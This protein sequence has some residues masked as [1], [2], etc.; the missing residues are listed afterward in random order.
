MTYKFQL[1]AKRSKAFAF[2]LA[3]TVFILIVNISVFWT[4][5]YFNDIE[6]YGHYHAAT[7]PSK[8]D[9]QF[10][11]KIEL[12]TLVV[13]PHG[14]R[15]V[16]SLEDKCKGED[17]FLVVVVTSAPGH[18]KQRDAI[19]QTWGNENILPHK[20]VKVLFALGRS[21]N[22]Q[23]EN[24]VQREV[25]T[26]QDIIQEEFLDSYRNLTIKTVMVL[27]WTVTFC[28]G[29]DYLMKTDDDMFVNI[30]T[31]VS[32]LKSL[33]DDKSSDLFIGD[34]HTGV[35]ALR[36]PANKH[37]VSMEDYENEV[38]PDYLSG[39]GYVMSMDVVRRL[40]VTALM[41]SPVP[42][43]DIYMGICA[44]RAGIAPRDHSGFTSLQFGFTVCSHRKIVT[45]HSYTPT[46]LLAMW[47]ALQETP[48]CGW[49]R[50]H[51]SMVYAKL[52]NFSYMIIPCSFRG[53]NVREEE[54]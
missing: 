2:V 40:Y 31:L 27:K 51:F 30:E 28:S 44:Q 7:I 10:V 21:D 37:Y 42:V 33:K 16:N 38:Y 25:R 52:L 8:I 6:R 46:E 20:N 12:S 50:T 45:S 11:R 19:R 9:D 54:Y 29:A 34:I 15:I 22:P 39:T 5:P 13:N 36:S 53:C 43:E 17:V 1:L 4:P 23:V 18:V 35:K 32:H 47:K 3:V 24:A 14:Y 48:E 49:L 26:F 41:T